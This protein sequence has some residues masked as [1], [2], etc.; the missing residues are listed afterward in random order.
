MLWVNVIHFSGLVG[1]FI[2]F[3]LFQIPNVYLN[4][5]NVVT[6]CLHNLNSLYNIEI[7]KK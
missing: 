5:I 3:S 6:H 1:P 2:S 7:L 4:P